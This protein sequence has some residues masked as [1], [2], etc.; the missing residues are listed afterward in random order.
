MSKRFTSF[1]AIAAAALLLAAPAQAQQVVKKAKA[2]QKVLKAGPVKS[3]DLKKAKAAR[4]KAESK[5]EGQ[6]FRGYAVKSSDY[7]MQASLEKVQE[8]KAVFEKQMEKNLQAI[9]RG[10]KP[11]QFSEFAKV[12]DLTIGQIMKRLSRSAGSVVTPRLKVKSAAKAPTDPTKASVT[13]TAGDVWED[14]SGYQMLLDADATA[15]GT[16]IPATGA[17]TSSGDV[18]AAIY[19]EFE[20]KIPTNADGSLTTSNIVI[21]N[22]ITIEIPAGTYDWV[23][24]NPTPGDRMWI[25]SANGNVG[26]RYDDYVFE[27]GKSYEFTVSLSGENDRV[28]VSI[29]GE[30]P[31][32]PDVVTPPAS[33]EALDYVMSFSNSDGSTGS[34]PV[35]V[36]VDGNDVYFQG[37]SKYIPSAWVIG[38]KD[39]N[40]ITF[41]GNQYMGEYSGYESYF[42]YTGPTTFVYDPAADTYSASG[43]VFGVIGGQ[44]YD[45]NYT[46]PVLNRVVE[47][48]ATPANP[49][50]TALTNGT[51]GWYITF[52]VPLVDVDGNPIVASKLSYEI[53]TDV[54]EEIAPLTFTPATHTK[55]TEDMT[56]IP[57]GFTDNFDFSTTQIYLNELYSSTWNKIGIKSI[58]TGGGETHETEIQWYTIKPYGEETATTGAN[59]DVLP[60]SNALNTADLF[61]V[62]GVIDSNNDG[63]TWGFDS[64]YY[65]YY[66]YNSS[67]D[68]DDW[69]ISPAIKLEAGKK[70]HFAIDAKAA[71]ASFPEKFEVFLGDAPKA[72]ALT[73]NVLAETTVTST[74]YVTYENENVAVSETGYYHFGIHATSEADEFRLMVANFLVEAGV[75]A[76]APAAV[77][78]FEVAQNEGK[79]ETL[80]SF[81]APTKTSA[82]ED[83]ES[84]TKIDI[85][86]DGKLI[87]SLDGTAAAPLLKEEGDASA[88]WVA[89]N[90]GWENA[91]DV[92]SFT[93]GAGVSAVLAN[94]GNSNGPKYYTSGTALRM[95]GKNTITLS[96]ATMTKVEF[97]LTGSDAQKQLEANVGSYELSGTIGTW[98]G[99]A[100]SITFTVPD[101]SG[102]QARIQKIEIWVS[103]GSSTTTALTP[104][105]AYT[106][107]DNAEDL[108]VGTHVYQ[109]IP[110]NEVGMGVKSEEKSIFLSAALEVPHTFDFAQDLLDLFNVIDDNNDG[111]TWIWSEANGA[112]YHYNGSNA[113]DDY[114]ISLPFNLKAGKN[115]N[116]IVNAKGSASYPE[117]LE[118]LAGKEPTV[119]GLNQTVLAP[120][121][122]NLGTYADYE[123]VF[124]PTEDGQYYFALHAVSDADML[125]LCVKLL[126]IEAAPEP[127]APAAIADLT[128]T[129]GAEGALEVNLAFT[130]PTK[131]KDGSDLTGTVD[132]KVYRN[133]ELATTLANLP[134]GS[135]Q[136]WKDTNVEDGKTYTYYVVAANESG[137]G[138]KSEKVSV[139]V[140]QDE[141]GPVENIVI[142]GTTPTTVTISWDAVTGVNGGYVNTAN[143]KYAVVSMHVETV[144][145]WQVLVIDDVLGTVTGATSG[146][147][148][149]PADE[150][151]QEYKYFGVVALNAEDPEPAVGDEYE[152]AD[153]AYLLAGAPYVLPFFESFEG[154]SFH[155]IWDYDEYTAA[156]IAD[157]AFDEDGIAVALLNEEAGEVY[158]ESGKINING[159]AKPTLMFAAQGNGVTSMKVFVSKDGGAYE[160]KATVSLTSEYKQFKVSLDGYQNG[161][162]YIRFKFVYD[163]AVP[164]EVDGD[165]NLTNYG[166]FVAIDAIRIA[167]LLEYNLSLS[168]IK[169]PAKVVAGKTAA[170]TATITNEG[171]ND[172]EGYTVVITAG[173][174]EIYN[175]T[176]DGILKSFES[177]DVTT[178]LETSIFDE[179]GDVTIKATVSTEVD[180]KEED[181]SLETI[182]TIT[183]STAK[184][185]ENVTAE[186][187]GD[188]GVLITWSAPNVGEATPQQITEDFEDTSVFEPFSLGGITADAHNGAF[189]DWTLYDGNGIT[190]YGFNNIEFPNNYEVA[191]WQVFNP[192]QLGTDAASQFAPHSGDQFLM[193]F[194]PAEENNCPPSD[195]WLISPVLTGDA[196]TISFFARAI[197]A[198]YGAE[199]FEVWASSTDKNVAS[200]TKVSS[201]STDAVEWTEF[202]A[203]LPAGTKYFAIRH[204]SEDIF[205]LLIDD[206]TYMALAGGNVNG[207]I[208]SFNIYVDGVLVATVEGDKTSYTVDPSTI[209]SGSHQF[210]VTAVYADGTESKPVS[211]T[212]TAT[213][214]IEQIANDG[215]P[216]DVYSLDG[217]LVR[218]QARS[219]GGLKG[220][221]VI[222]GRKVLVK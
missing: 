169:A 175:K 192:A 60:Y 81:K 170:I 168:N 180:L 19:A 197:T 68:A 160:E 182:I 22:S 95:Y 72:S 98:T 35:K 162:S 54:Q 187:K 12:D 42:F 114:L 56:V 96:G 186:D 126:T 185:P 205:G 91:E 158:F 193:S 26:G 142:T 181:N 62:F 219:L 77:T 112:Y 159:T 202:T 111:S 100:N 153:V 51:Y 121:D 119:T 108:T 123:G 143:V 163:C 129:P 23:I 39:G 17:L 115:Y 154:S 203:D 73:Q 128:A 28:D 7:F 173:D 166:D 208:V 106:Y 38:T 117:K 75:E 110:Y 220:V 61:A 113:A 24:T 199:T 5:V 9:A 71:G 145:F 144:L 44:Y 207:D 45:G 212:A 78:D 127:T 120:T 69:L 215:E 20:Y 209:A 200:F 52:N 167:D 135:A 89:A 164:Y 150:G 178:E 214:A 161:T 34:T 86:R 210:S 40:N 152:G 64:S 141:L 33:A 37:M 188:E 101:G 29:D 190:V 65:T 11:S 194:C 179:T 94:G 79:L 221:Y 90:A 85:F 13:L 105:A 125:N 74:D 27:A 66:R 16:I 57:Y 139:F 8:D 87:K 88:T 151:E 58:Y 157:E 41:A 165:G 147:F 204:T 55:L 177:V 172:I 25:A 99:E 116:V 30:A 32:G 195:H 148:N 67:N 156:I 134:V 149:Y 102:N 50:I 131:A 59:V 47:T 36:V 49:A 97:T 63:S 1:L 84:L 138:L 155:Y 133:N 93:I 191:A 118:V 43:P 83:L 31:A 201:Y 171:E 217:K 216:V 82:G 6:A 137:D 183:E 132:V 136:T 122:V 10:Q 198:Q 53:F 206:I 196:Q 80:I 21:D 124:T 103:G 174:K 222:N 184:G 189:G 107:V 46:N 146:T 15:Y 76:G 211:A 3:V 109:V 14:G 213:T 140:G 218:S 130:T 4:M 92:T 48:A 176:A 18:S 104:G 70:Y 2:S